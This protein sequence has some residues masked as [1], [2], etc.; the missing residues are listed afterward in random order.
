MT[1]LCVAGSWLLLWC[2]D[3]DDVQVTVVHTL[4][5]FVRITRASPRPPA[6]RGSLDR[7]RGAPLRLRGGALLARLFS[8][9]RE[10]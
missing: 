4:L 10:I 9:T 1:G 3:P 8:Q 5:V 2:V 6:A 7:A